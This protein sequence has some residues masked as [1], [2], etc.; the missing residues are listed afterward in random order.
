ME[1]L[2][3]EIAEK[4]SKE[5]GNRGYESKTIEATKN[6]GVQLTGFMFGKKGDTFFPTIYVDDN[7]ME[8]YTSGRSIQD[9][10][11]KME[12]DFLKNKTP[13]FNPEDFRDWEKVKNNIYLKLVMKEE[14]PVLDEVP[15]IP[16]LDLAVCFYVKAFKDRNGMGTILVKNQHMNFWGVSTEDIYHVA[17]ENMHKDNS[18]ISSMKDVLKGFMPAISEN[19]ID[20]EALQATQDMFVL[21]NAEKQFGAAYIILPE[22]QKSISKI[23]GGDFFIIPSSIHEVL[24]LRP[25]GMELKEI[26]FMVQEVNETQLLPEEVLSN[27]AYFY[28]SAEDR[29]EY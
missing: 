15:W 10:V 14:N 26:S 5:F 29:I 24:C 20:E 25:N 2:K 17:M 12:R 13:D 4:I 1:N 21:T 8:E 19:E 18:N 7:L 23:L 6:N 9:M 28:N 11:D 3:K 22:I 16:F 27:H